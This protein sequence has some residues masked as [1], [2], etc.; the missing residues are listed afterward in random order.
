M[1]ATN[2]THHSTLQLGSQGEEVKQL[3]KL[4]NSRLNHDVQVEIDGYFGTKTENAVKSIQ[5]Q[6]LLRQDG[7]VGS[8]TWKSLLANAP[9][10]KLVLSRGSF[11]EQV[12]RVQQLL[13]DGGYKITTVDSQFGDETQAAVKAFQT[14]R[15]FIADGVIG[16]K[17]WKALSD[18]AS[19]LAND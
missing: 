13:K 12:S 5:Y 4:L 11:G 1:I 6:F 7:I 19:F 16:E 17:T 14:S 10:N 3:Q 15:D 2:T 18:M 8:L 9:V